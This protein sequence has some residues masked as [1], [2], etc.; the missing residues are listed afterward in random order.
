MSSIPPTSYATPLP[1][2]PAYAHCM[3]F[4]YI[5]DDCNKAIKTLNDTQNKLTSNYPENST[6]S[7]NTYNE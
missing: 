2:L 1:E 7:N 5:K 3:I 4:A 6:W